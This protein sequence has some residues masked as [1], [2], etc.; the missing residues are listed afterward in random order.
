MRDWG[1]REVQTHTA[2][3]GHSWVSNPCFSDRNL[4]SHKHVK[5]RSVNPSLWITRLPIVTRLRAM[6][7]WTS[8]PVLRYKLWTNITT[9][10]NIRE[11][12]PSRVYVFKILASAFSYIISFNQHEKKLGYECH[13]S[14]FIKKNTKTQKSN[15]LPNR[16]A[17]KMYN[18]HRQQ[19]FT[20]L[21]I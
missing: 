5:L 21:F 19:D 18:Q 10:K 3:N 11:E 6:T 15:Y 17:G 7:Y 16:T 20:Y 4:C 13:H 1:S 14:H 12:V 2:R 8:V 9:E